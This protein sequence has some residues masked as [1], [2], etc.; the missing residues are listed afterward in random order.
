MYVTYIRYES[1]LSSEGMVRKDS[2]HKKSS[3]IGT[4]EVESLK[5]FGGKN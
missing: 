2:D 1:T 3:E 4:C 5:E